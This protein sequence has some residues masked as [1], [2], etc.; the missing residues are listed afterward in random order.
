MTKYTSSIREL[1]MSD[2]LHAK[3]DCEHS[4]YNNAL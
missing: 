1:D 4:Q 3:A 2:H